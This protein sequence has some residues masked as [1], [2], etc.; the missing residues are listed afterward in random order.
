[1]QGK[2]LASTAYAAALLQENGSELLDNLESP[3]AKRAAAAKQSNR[4]K[5]PSSAPHIRPKSAGTRRT[6]EV[7]DLETKAS[8]KTQVAH[9]KAGSKSAPA[10]KGEDR[11]VK[12]SKHDTQKGS[13]RKAATNSQS[14]WNVRVTR[15]RAK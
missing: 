7:E 15:A 3:L 13:K 2:I 14:V 5:K 4:G 12:S 8:K 10:A 6:R 1:M 9:G 11:F